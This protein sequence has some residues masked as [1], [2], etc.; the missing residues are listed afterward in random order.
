M[1]QVQLLAAY[2]MQICGGEK[3]DERRELGYHVST[4]LNTK[5]YKANGLYI[6]WM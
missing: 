4:K 2:A 3:R 6:K 5:A 1:K